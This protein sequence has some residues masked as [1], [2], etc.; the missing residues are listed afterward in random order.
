MDL[1]RN[2]LK[3]EQSPGQTARVIQCVQ[4]YVW[5]VMVRRRWRLAQVALFGVLAVLAFPSS[6]SALSALFISLTP[7]G[8][9]PATLTISG[10]DYPVWINED[11]VAHTVTFANGKCSVQVAPREIGQCSNGFSSGVG[12]YPY[13][14]DG[15]A[16]ASIVVALDWR[17]VTLGAK[18]HAIDRGSV[19][20][21]RG[22]LAVGTGSPPVFQGP[23]QPVTVLARPDRYHPFHR[24]ADV[25]AQPRRSRNPADAHSVWHLRV[26]ARHSAIYI[27]EANSQ[28]GQWQQAWSK[29]FRVRVGR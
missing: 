4:V 7:T 12:N 15:T 6:G 10:N 2:Y 26:R 25:T 16:Q 21:L 17:T 1:Q 22:T 23:R 20:T 13:T 8:P 11:T 14:V 3:W 24:I 18:S 19:L 29:P 27:V 28:P 9:S 5:V